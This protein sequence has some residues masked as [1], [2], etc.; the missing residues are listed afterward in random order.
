[1][2]PNC[3]MT[4]WGSD[5]CSV[6]HV[7]RV[8]FV[9]SGGDVVNSLLI[10]RYFE[11]GVDVNYPNCYSPGG[12][13]PLERAQCIRVIHLN[14]LYRRY[15]RQKKEEDVFTYNGHEIMSAIFSG[16]SRPV[17]SENEDD[18]ESGI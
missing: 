5:Y 18:S 1:M 14:D 13:F 11:R 9:T 17:D 15:I 10:S 3:G 4:G 6:C 12:H 16:Y 2:C 8:L 7:Q